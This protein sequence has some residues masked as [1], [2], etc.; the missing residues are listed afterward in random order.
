MLAASSI[1][2]VASSLLS[3]SQASP[4]TTRQTEYKT[5]KGDG[6]SSSGW[7]SVSD[8]LDF[9]TLHER[10][11]E[12]YAGACDWLKVDA[13]T[14]AENHALASAIRDV[15]DES[16]LDPRFILAAVIQ[17]SAGCVRVKTSYS[18][19]EGYRNPGLLQCF[20]GDHTCN[21]PE[22]GVQLTKLCP[23]SEIHGKC[24]LRVA[25]L[26]LDTDLACKV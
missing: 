7:P 26:E 11:T 22:A 8:W 18:T 17:E 4:L 16:G 21:D 13:N 25:Y 12:F 2:L 6:S 1:V 24:S 15:A 9:D 20:E 5:Y 14:D 19:N 23:D 3:L 10:N